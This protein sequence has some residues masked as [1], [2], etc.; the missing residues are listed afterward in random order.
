MKM[1]LFEELFWKF[2]KIN[3][4]LCF[5]LIFQLSSTLKSCCAPNFNCPSK[6]ESSARLCRQE[7][8]YYI[9]FATFI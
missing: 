4:L 8:A 6:D 7:A 5:Q 1:L 9:S 2:Y 3:I